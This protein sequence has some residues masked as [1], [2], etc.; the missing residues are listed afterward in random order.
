MK[1]KNIII[2]FPPDSST[3]ILDV[4]IILE[5]SNYSMDDFSYVVEIS[6]P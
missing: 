4:L 3:D 2:P 6:T 5:K 1:I